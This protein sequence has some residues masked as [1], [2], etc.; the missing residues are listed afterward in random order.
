MITWLILVGG[1]LLLLWFAV[2][3][4]T[5][6][7][8]EAQRRVWAQVAAERRRRSEAEQDGLCATCPFRDTGRA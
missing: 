6:M 3:I 2:L 8:T 1:V 5:Q 7:D 4:G